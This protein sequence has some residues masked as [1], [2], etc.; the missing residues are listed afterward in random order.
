MGTWLI[1]LEKQYRLNNQGNIIVS[2]I[3]SAQFYIFLKG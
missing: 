2:T 1:Y 3:Q